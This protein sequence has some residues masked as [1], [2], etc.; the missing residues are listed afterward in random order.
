MSYSPDARA[1]PRGVAF[2]SLLSHRDLSLHIPINYVTVPGVSLTAACFSNKQYEDAAA[3]RCLSNLLAIGFRRLEVDV[4]WDYTRR[5]WSLCPVQLGDATAL[6]NTTVLVAS[7]TSRTGAATLASGQ[8]T[9]RDISSATAALPLSSNVSGGSGSPE[10][11]SESLPSI[12][13]TST[14]DAT[15]SLRS[16]PTG[17]PSGRPAVSGSPGV[18]IQAGQF[19]CTETVNFEMVTTILSMYLQNTENNLNATTRYIILNLHRASPAP[20]FNNSAEQLPSSALPQANNL[21]SSALLVNNSVYLYTPTEL[22]A[23]RAN[24][25]AATSWLGVSRTFWP[26]TTYFRTVEADGH[27]TSPDGWPSEGFVELQRAERLLVGFGSVDPRM[28]G[29]NFSGDAAYIFPAGYLESPRNVVRS[30]NTITGGCLVQTNVN[31][32]GT[33]NSSWA[34][35]ELDSVAQQNVNTQ[36][37]NLVN[38]GISPMLNESLG[39]ASAAD[40]IA[41]YQSW[42][43]S[44]QWAWASGEPRNVGNNTNLRCAGLNSTAGRFQVADCTQSYYG[45]C[46]VASEPYQWQMTNM[47]GRYQAVDDACPSNTSFAVP[48]TALENSYLLA[49]WR[50]YLS[51]QSSQ[52]GSTGSQDTLLWLNFNDL[53][54]NGCWVIGQNTSCPYSPSQMSDG[55]RT[56]TVPTVAAVIV[57]VLAALT[58]FVKCASN[59]QTS[60]RRRR[61]GD[62]G[63]EYEGV[64]S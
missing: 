60:R 63:W 3:A 40:N 1:I 62:D 45:A 14:L 11:A 46:R 31:T 59:R 43:T 8:L 49:T 64:P 35:A 51:T 26:D 47:K 25:N 10:I 52:D 58:V 27:N 48:R 38:C 6:A 22:L 24:L 56:I 7:T 42:V 54:S 18:L 13:A 36:A 12:T 21:L 41:A 2:I 32:L 37:T 61:R 15:G 55:D 30:S 17:T 20:T 16:T 5:T 4:Y 57:F 39:N 53:E 19:A 44:A 33:V 23:D 34:T 29:Y 50:N 28:D 9:G